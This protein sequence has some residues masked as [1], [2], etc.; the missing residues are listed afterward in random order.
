MLFA[1]FMVDKPGMIETRMSLRPAHVEYVLAVKDRITIS[2]P[3][4]SD[5]GQQIGSLL[6]ME[7]PDRA[8]CEAWI[9][10]DP[11]AQAGIYATRQIYPFSKSLPKP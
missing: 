5:D 11:W 4:L 2:G 3:L 10:T 9:D 8:A 1:I 7:W 6:V